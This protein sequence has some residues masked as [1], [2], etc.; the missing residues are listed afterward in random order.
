MDS[1]PIVTSRRI[2]YVPQFQVWGTSGWGELP[3]VTV[4]KTENSRTIFVT[5]IGLADSAQEV[6]FADLVDHRGNHLPSEIAAPHVI[7]RPRSQTPTFIVG[8]ESRERF[9]IGRDQSASGPV[10]V[11][12]LI[13]EMGD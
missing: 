1:L 6:R 7:I 2:W 12:L 13:I 8:S 4:E 10:Q 9:R 3:L 5:K 11:D